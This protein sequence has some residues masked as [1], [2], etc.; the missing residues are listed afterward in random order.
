MEYKVAIEECSKNLTAREKLFIKDSSNAVRLDAA[1]AEGA[2]NIEPDYYAILSVY[3]E[4][5]EN[6][7]Y[8]Q[9]V[10]VDT[11]GVKYI[12]GSESFFKAFVE[13]FETM[14]EEPETYTIDVYRMESKNYKGKSFITCSI[15]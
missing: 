10:V 14:A 15:V 6:P 3:N 2:L 4:K 12:T 1:T 13:I 11:A 8:N 5:A 9:Y 7:E